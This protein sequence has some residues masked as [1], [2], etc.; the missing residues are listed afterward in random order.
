MIVGLYFAKDVE[1][2]FGVAVVALV[3]ALVD[4][5]PGCGGACDDAAVIGVGRERAFGGEL[6]GVADHAEEREFA[7]VAV[8]DPVGVENLVAAVLGVDLREHDELGVGRVALHFLVSGDEVVDFG[9]AHGEAPVDV[10][11]AEGFGAFGHEWHGAQ[12]GGLEVGEE[13]G[14]VGVDRFGHTVVQGEEGQAEVVHCQH[15]AVLSDQAEVD[16]P[17]DACDALDGAVVEDVG[18]LGGPRGDRALTR[19]DEEA[20]FAVEVAVCGE[21]GEGAFVGFVAERVVGLDEIGFDGVDLGDRQL[22]C[23]SVERGLKRGETEIGECGTALKNDRLHSSKKEGT[24]NVE[25]PTSN[26]ELWK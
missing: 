16:A 21:E 12:L 3:A 17:L 5:E 1:L 2:R 9:R 7:L 11:L 26:I 23:S 22:G 13:V 10:G 18:R 25:R 15:H 8:D 14:Y 19:G 4:F 6:V 24:L 20:A